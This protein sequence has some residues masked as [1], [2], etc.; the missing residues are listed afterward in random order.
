MIYGRLIKKDKFFRKN[1][2]PKKESYALSGPSSNMTTAAFP[3][4]K[5]HI[6]HHIRTTENA[7][8]D[9]YSSNKPT[10]LK[11][12][13]LGRNL[14]KLGKLDK[15]R[16]NT[17]IYRITKSAPPAPPPSAKAQ[18]I[19]KDPV[20]NI[21][22]LFPGEGDENKPKTPKPKP[23]PAGLRPNPARRFKNNA[24]WGLTR[25]HP[26]KKSSMMWE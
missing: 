7:I 13:S 23:R 17:G 20:Y 4:I 22:K 5:D 16:K 2:P 21:S 8:E 12:Q 25:W 15:I 14:S 10:A 11:I 6:S 26:Y 19:K 3:I 1:K 24:G 18:S 9:N